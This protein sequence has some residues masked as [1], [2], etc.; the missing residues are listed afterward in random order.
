[1][2]KEPEI[3]YPKIHKSN[4]PEKKNVGKIYLR[5]WSV[6][7]NTILVIVTIAIAY[8][9]FRSSQDQSDYYKK[10]ARPFV[11]VI[12]DS[13]KVISIYAKLDIP[14]KTIR[15]FADVKYSVKNFGAL[16]AKEF[17]SKVAFLSYENPKFR[18]ED[19]PNST[20]YSVYPNSIETFFANE[21][22]L[23]VSAKEIPL[24]YETNKDGVIKNLKLK[25]KVESFMHILNQY[26]DMAEDIHYNLSIVLIRFDYIEQPDIISIK[27][28][29][30]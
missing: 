13:T 23:F 24:D 17:R 16:P 29:F 22:S 8:T 28:Y 21:E 4:N 12:T 20:I 25:N 18:F 5:K 1:M 26:K 15:F 6:I 9:A 10:T 19:D 30:D 27:S 11:G 7:I 2:K 14:T 3:K